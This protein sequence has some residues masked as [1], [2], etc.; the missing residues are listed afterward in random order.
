MLTE[1]I[2]FFKLEDATNQ[3]EAVQNEIKLYQIETLALKEDTLEL[4]SQALD[5]ALGK[6]FHRIL[7][8]AS[9]FLRVIVA[10]QSAYF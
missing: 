9:H 1:I 5:G 7:T 3:V 4:T 2:L 8:V 6:F 10:S